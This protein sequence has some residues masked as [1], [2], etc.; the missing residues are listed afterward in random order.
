MDQSNKQPTLLNFIPFSFPTVAV[1]LLISGGLGPYT[2]PVFI[3]VLLLGFAY[4]F[5]VMFAKKGIIGAI[6]NIY[7]IG[8]LMFGSGVMYL[9]SIASGV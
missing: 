9:M 6:I 3:G 1:L 7:V 5:I 2:I 8:I 4:S